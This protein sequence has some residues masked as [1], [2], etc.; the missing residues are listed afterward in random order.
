MARVKQ[1][2]WIGSQGPFIFYTN[3]PGIVPIRVQLAP[4]TSSQNVALGSAETESEGNNDTLVV[5]VEISASAYSA[6]RAAHF[7]AFQEGG[8]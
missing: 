1:K 2:I 4:E 6:Y 3:D 5:N 7:N 8:M